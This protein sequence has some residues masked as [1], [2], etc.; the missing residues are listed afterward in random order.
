MRKIHE[1]LNSNLTEIRGGYK[2]Q[3]WGTKFAEGNGKFTL[4]RIESKYWEAVIE[5]QNMEV[6]ATGP[7]GPQ[8][9]R[10]AI[11]R[12]NYLVKETRKREEK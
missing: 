12:Y 10:N 2:G 6:L 9:T 4:E 11:N 7:S 5:F 8:A 1:T 3:K